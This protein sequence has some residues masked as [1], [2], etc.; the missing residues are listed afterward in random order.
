MIRK[1]IEKLDCG[2]LFLDLGSKN[3]LPSGSTY[4]YVTSLTLALSTSSF[5]AEERLLVTVCLADNIQT[6]MLFLS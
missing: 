1:S 3:T 5:L 4:S 2:S 6:E